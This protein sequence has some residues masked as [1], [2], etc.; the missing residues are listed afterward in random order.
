MRL[1][2]DSKADAAYIY[3]VEDIGA[4]GVAFT[5][6]CDPALV[7]GEI[8]LDFDHQRRLIGV[9]ILSASR[10]LP[11]GLLASYDRKMDP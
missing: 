7:D 8:N 5:V 9:E 10:K 6:P 2:Y 4:G 1:E 11:P 3:L